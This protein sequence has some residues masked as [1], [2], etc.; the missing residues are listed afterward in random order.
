MD[1]DGISIARNKICFKA[2]MPA[3]LMILLQKCKTVYK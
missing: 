1:T 3:A 2:V